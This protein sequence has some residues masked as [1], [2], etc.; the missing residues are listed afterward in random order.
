MRCGGVAMAHSE[1]PSRQTSRPRARRETRSAMIERHPCQ[2][3]R[4]PEPAPAG[5]L[6]TLQQ[7]QGQVGIGFAPLIK[8]RKAHQLALIVAGAAE[9]AARG[10][11]QQREQDSHGGMRPMQRRPH[12]VAQPAHLGQA[13]GEC[14]QKDGGGAETLIERRSRA[15]EVDERALLGVPRQMGQLGEPHQQGTLYPG[16]GEAQQGG[17][18]LT[19]EAQYAGLAHRLVQPHHRE[20][21]GFPL[22]PGDDL[23][24][25]H[26]QRLLGRQGAAPPGEFPQGAGFEHQQQEQEVEQGLGQGEIAHRPET[27]SAGHPDHQQGKEP[28]LALLAWRAVGAIDLLAEAGE[29]RHGCA[30]SKACGPGQQGLQQGGP[31][32]DGR[33]RGGEGGHQGIPGGGVDHSL[34]S[35]AMITSAEC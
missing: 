9:S 17:R 3:Q 27:G 23:Q 25:R 11:G 21:A 28:G 33:R 5:Q 35:S 8:Y 10:P 31:H 1:V 20:L 18:P 34:P 14:Q 4:E 30:G 13:Q 12:S 32:H 29:Q 19:H 24:P 2:E 16:Q 15:A 7:V 26:D 22:E 6:Q